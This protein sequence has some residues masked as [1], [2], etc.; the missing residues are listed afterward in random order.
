M[1]DWIFVKFILICT[2]I[3]FACNFQYG[4]STVYVN[5]PVDEFK[6]FINQ[7][8][9]K[10]GTIMTDSYYDSI[11]NWI[12]NIWFIGFFFGI[13]INPFICDRYGR[14]ISFLGANILSFVGSCIRCVAIWAYVSELL[15]VGRIFVS[16][17][18]GLT[19]QCQILYLQESSPTQYRG[20]AGF[21]SEISFAISCLI[22]MFLGMYDILGS[23]L[24]WF[25]F[26]PIIP[27]FLSIVAIFYMKETPKYLLIVKKDK[28][29][30][31]ESIKFFHG[32]D[33]NCD[34]V[35]KEIEMESSKDEDQGTFFELFKEILKNKHLL[36]ALALSCCALQN[37]VGLWSLLLS[38]TTFL[39]SVKLEN[40]LSQFSSTLMALCYVI[41]TLSGSLVIEKFGRRP[42]LL[43][44][45]TAN[46][47][48][49]V[50]FSIFSILHNEISFGKYI[51]LISL[52]L[53]GFTYGSA[54]GPISWFISSELVD[55]KYRSF[56][57]SLCYAFNTIMVVI[58]SFI[59]LPLYN[60]IGA[61]TFLIL[62]VLP[63]TFCLLLLFLYLPETK[64]REIHE[65]ID[66]MKK[67][68]WFRTF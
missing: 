40:E 59:V 52:L 11:W 31:G 64:G 60:S 22:G 6:N 5:T 24:L 33:A 2:A 41:G 57:Q 34:L 37:T 28:V 45:S 51:C 10:R 1:F 9:I 68:K 56:I 29:L 66:Q 58:T 25:L 27:T 38:S 46:T 48:V 4:F 42:M 62:Y 26:F 53:Y 30:A 32:K 7:S 44:F 39:T 35:I 61:Y 13:L 18:T 3:A 63:S 17:A 15:I 54:V 8:E 21:I 20:I 19:Y 50:I 49:L 65:I 12:V 23:H 47:I 36:K 55:Q 16:V 14:R 43:G 67:R